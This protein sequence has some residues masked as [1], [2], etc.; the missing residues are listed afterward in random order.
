MEFSMKRYWK[1]LAESVTS[2]FVRAAAEGL[3]RFLLADLFVWILGS[4]TV[5]AIEAGAG[6]KTLRTVGEALYFGWISMTTVGFGDITA[7]S[8]AGRAVIMVMVFAH[9]FIIALLSAAVASM[10]VAQRIKEGKGLEKVRLEGHLVICG[11]NSNGG[12]ILSHL[13]HFEKEPIPVVLVSSMSEE[14]AASIL[15]EYE[16]LDLKWVSG[17]YIHESVLERAN[18]K[19]ARGVIILADYKMRDPDKSDER[20]ILTTLAVKEIRSDVMVSVEVFSRS[21]R[22][23]L[24]RARADEI[25]VAGESDSFF[26]LSATLAP[27]L[28]R[29]IRN[30]LS[31]DLGLEVWVCEIPRRFVGKPFSEYFSHAYNEA[32]DIS[33]GVI[34]HEPGIGLTDVLSDDYTQIDRFIEEKFKKAKLGSHKLEGYYPRLNPPPDYIITENDIAVCLQKARREEE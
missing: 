20:A 22:P 30:M 25:I 10:L 32:G 34:T 24:R 1:G 14:E 7:L 23:H 15:E 6:T 26:L 3:W 21:A 29:M 18:I 9:I 4:F 5:Y 16:W 27:G 31:P 19:R 11:W 28:N 13:L 17:D 33:L 12:R 8:G 2:M